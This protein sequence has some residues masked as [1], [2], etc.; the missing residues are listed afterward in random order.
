MQAEKVLNVKPQ[1]N[2]FK[3]SSGKKKCLHPDG[4]D[5]VNL[6][7]QGSRFIFFSSRYNFPSST[8]P[9]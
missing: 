9:C 3:K 4:T 6:T 1:L 5:T 7:L 8:V 2:C